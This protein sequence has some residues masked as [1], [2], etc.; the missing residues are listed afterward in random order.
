MSVACRGRK[1]GGDRKQLFMKL[2]KLHSRYPDNIIITHCYEEVRNSMA[3]GKHRTKPR[4][5]RNIS[6]PDPYGT[7]LRNRSKN[8]KYSLSSSWGQWSKE[9]L[10]YMDPRFSQPSSSSNRQ[11][12]KR[13][14]D[15]FG[16]LLDQAYLNSVD[17]HMRDSR[18]MVCFERLN[19]SSRRS[20]F[21]T[22]LTGHARSVCDQI[23]SHSRSR[24]VRR[25]ARMLKSSILD[26]LER[27]VPLENGYFPFRISDYWCAVRQATET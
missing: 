5:A 12:A 11:L 26:E 10:C 1:R 14:W 15:T 19:D 22:D 18:H 17:A 2:E 8:V 21:I 4:N 24:E 16:L 3:K 25:I 9:E 20:A 23:T 6:L 13:E 7:V 27:E